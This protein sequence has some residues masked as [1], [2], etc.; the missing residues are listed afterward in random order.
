M[1]RPGTQPLAGATLLARLGRDSRHA[2]AG[3]VLAVS[4]HSKTL[5]APP[6]PTSAIDTEKGCVIVVS[7]RLLT[8]RQGLGTAGPGRGA[9]GG[10]ARPARSCRHCPRRPDVP[11][12]AGTPRRTR[13][14][15]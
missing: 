6:P 10:L 4:E 1:S 7:L 2:S 9:C 8:G 14:I 5:R 12:R 3:R 13:K 15:K 11:A